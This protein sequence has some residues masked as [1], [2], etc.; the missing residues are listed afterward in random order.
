MAPAEVE[1]A[2][3][4]L[5]PGV[6]YEPALTWSEAGVDSF[7]R[8]RMMLALE[9]STGAKLSFDSFAAGARV[10]DLARAGAAAELGRAASAPRIMLLPGVFGDEPVLADLRRALEPDGEVSTIALPD[11]DMPAQVSRSMRLTAEHAAD[12]IM[13]LQPSGALN[14][15]GFSFGAIAAFETAGRLAAR[16]RDVRSVALLD[17]PT[18]ASADGA[19][20]PGITSPAPAPDAPPPPPLAP[21]G[22]RVRGLFAQGVRMSGERL[23]YTTALKLRRMEAA[24]VL[25]YSNQARYP[26]ERN[27]RRRREVLGGLRGEALGGWRPEP[28]DGRV[29]LV[30]TDAFGAEG[31]E[32]FWRAT[33][34]NLEVRHVGGE[35][36]DLFKPGKVEAVSRRMLEHARAG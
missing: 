31:S 12:Q 14:V 18:S 28:Y 25:A 26:F 36:S 15:A 5:F 8:L 27:F 30:T 17:P 23:A 4:E 10:G 13:A 29:L 33:C 2:W 35:H 1:R 9:Q 20:G 16:G 22:S 21:I 34:P 3:S 11:W 19:R 32:R 24:R 7:N 6:A